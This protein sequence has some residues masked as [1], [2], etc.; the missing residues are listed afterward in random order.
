MTSTPPKLR[1]ILL[2]ED[3]PGDVVL[4][5]R[6]FNRITQQAHIHS[7]ENGVLALEYLRD[8]KEPQ[9]DLILLDLNLPL[10]SGQDVLAEIKRDP[11]LR[12]IPVLILTSSRAH[13]DILVAYDMSANC[14]MVKPGDPETFRQLAGTIYRHWFEFAEIAS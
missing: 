9:P 3:N 7:V 1:R 2:V 12:R 8:P 14:Y 13:E 6:A 5:R 4:T 11:V 10:R